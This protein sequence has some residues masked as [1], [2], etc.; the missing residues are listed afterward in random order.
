MSLCNYAT[1]GAAREK[2]GERELKEEKKNRWTFYFIFL[3][4]F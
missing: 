2:E 3:V 1:S 4:I